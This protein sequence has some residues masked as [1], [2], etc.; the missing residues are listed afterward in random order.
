MHVHMSVFL[1]IAL[2]NFIA[3]ITQ[4]RCDSNSEFSASL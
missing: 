4:S 1:F 2:N 3:V